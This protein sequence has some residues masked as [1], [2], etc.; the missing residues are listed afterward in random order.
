MINTNL[1]NGDRYGSHP[2][3]LLS[4]SLSRFLFQRFFCYSQ[5][6]AIDF[7]GETAA[8]A[9]TTTPLNIHHAATTA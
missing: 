3:S 4:P 5:S 6:P 7:R 8:V 2:E 9:A 1:I